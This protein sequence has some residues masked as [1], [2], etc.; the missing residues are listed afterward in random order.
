MSRLTVRRRALSKCDSESLRWDSRVS[1]IR[2]GVLSIGLRGLLHTTRSP[3]NRTQ[4][5]LAYDSE[6][7]RWDSGVSCI[8][9]G[10]LSI[11]LRGLLHTTRSPI[12]GTQESLAYDS[13]SYRWDSGVPCIRLGVLSMGLRVPCIRRFCK[14]SLAIEEFAS[15]VRASSPASGVASR[16]TVRR[17]PHRSC[18]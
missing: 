8:R 13:E 18:N 10:V 9:L 12:D 4:G 16:P 17:S 14:C 1:Y 2:L 5:S 15:V 7:Y 6:S 11:G 3:I